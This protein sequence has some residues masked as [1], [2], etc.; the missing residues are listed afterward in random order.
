MSLVSTLILTFVTGYSSPLET[1][2]ESGN[3]VAAS[4]VVDVAVQTEKPTLVDAEIQT[5]FKFG[6]AFSSF[7]DGVNGSTGEDEKR[8]RVSTE[9]FDPGTWDAKRP[10][11]TIE[12]VKGLIPLTENLVNLI[13]MQFEDKG[14]FTRPI[15][16]ASFA[17]A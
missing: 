4:N 17:L 12:P 11:L 1:K 3:A 6:D 8:K 15:S 13:L 7:G 2:D 5:S 9:R 14:S 16:E 10:R